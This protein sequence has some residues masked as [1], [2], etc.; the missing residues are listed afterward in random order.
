[1]TVMRAGLRLTGLAIALSAML[2]TCSRTAQ[3]VLVTWNTFGNAGTE[4]TEPSVFVDP[5]LVGPV[6]LTLGAGVTP[7]ANG[8]RFGG[9]AWFDTGDSSPP[10]LAQS[11]AGNDYIEF[12]ITPA[13]NF[14]FTPT[15]FDFIWDR[16]ATGPDNVTLRSSAD[17]FA[18]DLGS[19]LNMASLSSNSITIT[20]LTNIAIATTFR[21]YGWDVASGGT[22]GA[23]GT[24][25]FDTGANAVNVTLQGF[26]TAIPEASSFLFG[27]LA[28]CAAGATLAVRRLRRSANVAAP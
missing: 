17:G 5:G 22:A 3:A 8:N 10:T 27:G 2:V 24:A 1:M 19:A 23:A 21:L 13:V 20:G 6:N 25:G 28:C 7:A 15:S 4:T 18:A 14:A 11:I 9:S 12:I 16:S 26:T